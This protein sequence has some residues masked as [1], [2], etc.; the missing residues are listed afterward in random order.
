MLLLRIVANEKNAPLTTSVPSQV[1]Q[2][3]ISERGR[4]GDEGE[5]DTL[6]IISWKQFDDR[7]LDVVEEW[8]QPNMS[9]LN[10]AAGDNWLEIAAIEPYAGALGLELPSGITR[11]FVVRKSWNYNYAK[12]M[13]TW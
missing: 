5:S 10:K 11:T 1:P 6:T 4:G 8:L 2:W 3:V 13:T 12:I 9:E 7:L